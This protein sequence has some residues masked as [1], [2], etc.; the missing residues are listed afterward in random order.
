MDRRIELH[1]SIRQQGVLVVDDSPLQ[2]QAAVESLRQL[3]VNKIFE[4]CDGKDAL[5]LLRTLFQLPAIIVL[6]LEM[7]GMDG[8]EMVQQMAQEG[9]RPSVLLASSAD[10]AILEVVQTMV[11][12]LGMPLLGAVPKPLSYGVL[13][14][15]LERF[16]ESVQRGNGSQCGEASGITVEALRQAI[17]KGQILP[18]YQP[19]IALENGR[20]SGLESLARWRDDNGKLI[21]PAHFIELAESNDLIEELTLRMLD[22]V[23][24]DLS[25][26]HDSGFYPTVAIN[27]SA[28]SLG[29]RN[30]ANEIIGRVDAAH[31]SPSALTLEIT[32]SALIGDLAASLGALGRL[33]LKGYGLS[34]DDYGTGFSSM[35]QLSRLPFTELKIDRSFVRHSDE[36]WQLRTILESAIG[37]A[38]RLGLSTVAEGIE[39]QAELDLL[40]SLGC[41]YAQGYLISAPMPVSALLPW[42]RREQ[43]NLLRISTE[44]PLR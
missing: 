5:H 22:A 18:F 41:K 1:P 15:S 24:Y 21:P 44:R 23:L 36:K 19:K 20:V 40:R 29:D 9:L 38:H 11:E 16:E 33:R 10:T 39:T 43:E 37:M 25:A 42:I 30:F 13:L 12:T 8:I 4:A 27:I 7:P 32:E 3:G 26:W 6:D 28:P 35:Q 17:G 2:R 14:Q 34:I 31:I